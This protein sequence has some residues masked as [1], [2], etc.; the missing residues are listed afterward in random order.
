MSNV[1][2]P[3]PTNECWMVHN[4]DAQSRPGAEHRV[5]T[6]RGIEKRMLILGAET[7]GIPLRWGVWS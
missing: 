2:I 3:F 1:S 6:E 4:D 5:D 7:G